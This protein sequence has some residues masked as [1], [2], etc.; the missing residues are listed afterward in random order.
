MFLCSRI[1]IQVIIYHIKEKP[2][3][4]VLTKFLWVDV[5]GNWKD[6]PDP[7]VWQMEWILQWELSKKIGQ[8]EYQVCE[9]TYAYIP[10]QNGVAKFRN[11]IT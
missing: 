7:Q 10:K 1:I 9:L 4:W 6:H 2:I 11:K 5:E 8:E 3:I